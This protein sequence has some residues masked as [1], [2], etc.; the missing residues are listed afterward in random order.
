MLKN[1][2]SNWV[3]MVA[4]GLAT[5]FLMPYNLAHL[6]TAQYGLW[7]VIAALIGYLF[8]L[9]LGVPM[10]S[11]REM[12]Q[13]IATGDVTKLNEVVTSCAILYVALGLI[14]VALGIPLLFYF[15]MTYAIPPDLAPSARVAFSLALVQIGIGFFAAMPYAIL[16]AYQ[17]FVAKNVLLILAI[18]VRLAV[19]LVVILVYPNLSMLAVVNLSVTVFELFASWGYVLSA[20]PAI[21]PRLSLFRW[22]TLQG[23]VGFS[24]YVFLLALGSQLAFQ[25]SALVIGHVMTPA[26]V[27]TFAVPNSLMLI[28]MQFLGGISQVIMPVSTNLQ[29]KGNTLALRAIVFQWTKISFALSWCA[30]LFLFVFGPSFLAYWIKSAYT[31]E[32]G[33]ALRILMASYLVFLPVR[34]VA[35]PVLMGLGRAKWP[36]IATLAAGVLNLALS[37]VWVHS[38]G[39]VGAAWG[40]FVPN[41]LLSW[42]L[43]ILLCRELAIAPRNFLAAT[44]PLAM[45]GGV[46]G[47][48]AL[49]WWHQIWHPSGLVGLGIAGVLTVIVTTVIWTQLVLRNDPHVTLPQFRAL[50][51]GRHP[52]VRS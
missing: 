49:G 51:E 11:V 34:G 27:V 48:A 31:P 8:L 21:R 52:W 43:I 23:I 33:E 10:A 38:Y 18:G 41:L 5:L 2:G 15:E 42:V 9:Q 19:N 20:Y 3:V 6:G 17:A 46:A 37:F 47:L 29:T 44:V 50:F 22:T 30:G 24:A 32:A 36:T 40:T 16:S 39:I 28:L 14:G 4:T 45:A 35:L 7:L 26:D 25:T 13:A 12:T 1:I